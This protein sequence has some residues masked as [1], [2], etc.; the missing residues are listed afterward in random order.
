MNLFPEP[1]A[2]NPGD[3][4]APERSLHL[5]IDHGSIDN[6]ILTAPVPTKYLDCWFYKYLSK[7]FY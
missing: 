2:C 4:S 5:P 7:H 3:L 1:E 6:L